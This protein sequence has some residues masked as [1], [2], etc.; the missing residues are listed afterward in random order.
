MW[1]LI[2]DGSVHQVFKVPTAPN[3]QRLGFNIRKLVTLATAQRKKMW[4]L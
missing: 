4:V 3:T 2:V 1:A